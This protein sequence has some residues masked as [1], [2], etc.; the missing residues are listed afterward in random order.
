MLIKSWPVLLCWLSRRNPGKGFRATRNSHPFWQ[1]LLVEKGSVLSMVGGEYAVLEVGHAALMRANEIHSF[2]VISD[3]HI[4][5]MKF[6]V[7]DPWLSREFDR[8]KP[9]FGPVS[10]P[11]RE[12]LDR[13]IAEGEHNDIYCRDLATT[14]LCELLFHYLRHIHEVNPRSAIRKASTINERAL[15]G[16]KAVGR[17]GVEKIVKYM[18]KHLHEDLS[19]THLANIFGYTRSYLCEL[20]SSTIDMPPM[21]FLTMIRLE[22]AKELLANSDKTVAEIAEAS[23]F[24]SAKQLWQTCR[25]ETGMSP[26]EFRKKNAGKDSLTIRFVDEW[27]VVRKSNPDSGQHIL[28][29]GLNL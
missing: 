15:A 29:L 25:R 3:S 2:H 19:L 24:A 26:R 23:G 28:S 8:S 18:E 9:I 1:Y 5:E 12:A 7:N 16:T 22:R 10:P 6:F 20:F 14:A 17:P 21:R 13:I 11:I 4:I 27:S